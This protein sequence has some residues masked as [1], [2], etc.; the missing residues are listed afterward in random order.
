MVALILRQ[1]LETE[2]QTAALITPDRGL[3]R[4]VAA[5]LRRW[6]VEVDDS[7]G[8]PLGS[9]PPGT[10]L[11]LLAKAL[12]AELAPVPLLELLKHPLAACGRAPSTFRQVV[13]ALER[14][15]LRGPRPPAGLAGSIAL[16]A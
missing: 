2:G 3:A 12:A 11:R 7:A 16:A 9:T 1:A 14:R 10:F 6:E 15:I 8:Q 13:R 4:R 5:E